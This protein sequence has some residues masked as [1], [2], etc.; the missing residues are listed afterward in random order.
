M[1]GFSCCLALL[2]MSWP[3]AL[4]VFTQ[5]SLILGCDPRADP[6]I[7]IP[8]YSVSS[9]GISP[10][11]HPD[12]RKVIIKS[13][14]RKHSQMGKNNLHLHAPCLP[15]EGAFIKPWQAGK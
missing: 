9:L 6:V 1:S 15:S 2:Q 11:A 14:Q 7:G 3:I 10:R 13:L 12:A 4:L 8:A 5:T